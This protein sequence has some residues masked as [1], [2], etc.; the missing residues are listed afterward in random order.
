MAAEPWAAPTSGASM[1]TTRCPNHARFLTYLSSF[2][3]QSIIRVLQPAR[4]SFRQGLASLK[5]A[6]EAG[7]QSVPRTFV[8]GDGLPLGLWVHVV[9]TRVSK[10]A[11]SDSERE[12]YVAAAGISDIREQQFIDGLTHIKAH[13]GAKATIGAHHVCDDGFPLSGFID[14]FSDSLSEH[15]FFRAGGAGLKANTTEQSPQTAETVPSQEPFRLDGCRLLGPLRIGGQHHRRQTMPR[16]ERL[17]QTN[18]V[19]GTTT[20]PHNCHGVETH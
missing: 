13:A 20:V 19:C 17:S 1:N 10:G 11:L 6:R 8:D 7:I 14:A 15:R 12:A 16:P 2:G 18:L 3:G 5:A 9:Q 4:V